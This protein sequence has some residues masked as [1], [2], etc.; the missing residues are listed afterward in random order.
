[1]DKKP[2]VAHRRTQRPER[3]PICASDL[4]EPVS[5]AHREAGHRSIELRCPE[6]ETE[7]S[8]TLDAE[9]AHAFNVLLFEAGD[10]LQRSVRRLEVEWSAGVA[11]EDDRFVE[12]LRAGR[13]L[14][15]DF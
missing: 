4:V 11:E 6:C 13:I 12:A 14:P 15:I 7:F 9:A 1:V 5:W 3:C 2:H 8:V 10:E